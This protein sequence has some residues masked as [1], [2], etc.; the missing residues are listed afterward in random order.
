MGLKY[1]AAYLMCALAGNESPSA[2]DIQKVLESVESDYDESI[3]S[4]LVSELEGKTI[5]EVIAA[6]KE[7]LKGFGGGGGGGVA[8]AAAG[9]GGGADAPKAEKKEEKKVEEEEEEE[10]MDFDLF[11]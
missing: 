9:G 7:K 4:K 1:S 10:E 8:V 6:G 3:A 5:H 11:G 2:S